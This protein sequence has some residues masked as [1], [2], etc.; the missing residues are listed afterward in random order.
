[1]L[2]RRLTLFDVVP[3]FSLPQP[4]IAEIQELFLKAGA[5]A[6]SAQDILDTLRDKNAHVYAVRTTK[7]QIIAI[8]AL[9]L[10]QTLS[11]VEGEIRDIAIHSDW[12]EAPRDML[13]GRLID[14]LCLCAIKNG[15]TLARLDSGVLVFDPKL[16]ANVV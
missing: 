7:E 5:P 3:D 4:R 6:V 10:T 8:G 12:Q 2:V 1:M 15:V 13:H 9:Y 11:G 16:F 14:V